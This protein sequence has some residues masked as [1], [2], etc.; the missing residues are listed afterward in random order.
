MRAL[1]IC[2]MAAAAMAAGCL[3]TTAFKCLQDADCGAGGTCEPIGFC[4]VAN[5]RCPGTGR[6]FSDSAGQG[7]ASSCV[8]SGGVDP[9]AGVDAPIDGMK[10]I[11][12]PPGYA[13]VA[14]SSHFYRALANVA[15]N[16]ARLACENTG[17]VT[18][19]A[20]PADAAELANLA[21]VASPPFWIGLDDQAIENTFVNHNNVPAMFTPWEAGEPD[22]G[23]P[24]EDC[25]EAVSATQIATD[26]C[27]NRH[28]AV[29]ECEP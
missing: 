1:A 11:G 21:A 16:E 29:C 7:L 23:P 18:Y 3:R 27:G 5:A 9:D 10:P 4:S 17:L 12:C 28:A 19:L 14:G 2:L 24:A 6:S 20:D 25:V 26:R 15:W 8:P 22:D 13:A